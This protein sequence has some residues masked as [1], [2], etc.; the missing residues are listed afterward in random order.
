MVENDIMNN[1]RSNIQRGIPLK[2]EKLL[3]N[4]RV[5]KVTAAVTLETINSTY[6]DPYYTYLAPCGVWK[7]LQCSQPNNRS[8]IIH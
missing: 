1:M 2:D 3:H 8:F 6:T 5:S 7:C 4:L